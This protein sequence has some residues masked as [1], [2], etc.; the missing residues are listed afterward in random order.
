MIAIRNILLHPH[1]TFHTKSQHLK[2]YAC[3]RLIIYKLIC[4]IAG[5]P[6]A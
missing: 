6:S 3:S 5:G 2:A 1:F 4:T